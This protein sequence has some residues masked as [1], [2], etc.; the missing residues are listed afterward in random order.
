M[1]ARQASAPVSNFMTVTFRSNHPINCFLLF[2]RVTPEPC[3]VTRDDV[4]AN[5]FV[6]A[7]FAPLPLFRSTGETYRSGRG[8][9]CFWYTPLPPGREAPYC[10]LHTE[11]SLSAYNCC[12]AG[13]VE[14][15]RISVDIRDQQHALTADFV[16]WKHFCGRFPK[17]KKFL[18][19]Y[20]QIKAWTLWHPG[21]FGDFRKK[22]PKRT[23]L[24]AGI[25]P[26]LYGLRTRSKRQKTRQVF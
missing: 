17:V 16:F 19:I 3:N 15:E 5:C 14:R 12:T 2:W 13:D 23:W 7:C 4:A 11:R 20:L 18:W 21:G 22:T 26:V 8:S 9:L 25:S 6:F 24:C 10:P 1:R